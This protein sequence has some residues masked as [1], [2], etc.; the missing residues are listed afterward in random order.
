MYG[1]YNRAPFKETIWVQDGWYD[2]TVRMQP[3]MVQIPDPM[4]K[5]CNYSKTH[6]DPRCEGC[7]WNTPAL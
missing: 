6:P 1:C 4:S 7:R 2:T 3:R 5:E